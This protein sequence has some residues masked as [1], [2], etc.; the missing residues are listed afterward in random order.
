MHLFIIIIILILHDLVHK[1][2][3]NYYYLLRMSRLASYMLH[4][5]LSDNLV[6]N[7]L[8]MA[9]KLIYVNVKN[10]NI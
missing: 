5:L 9:V 6:L 7:L 1:D 4:V 8:L 3:F 10:R 2:G